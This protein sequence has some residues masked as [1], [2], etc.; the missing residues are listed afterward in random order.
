M[1]P[2]GPGGIAWSLAL[3]ALAVA[4]ALVGDVVRSLTARWVP[5]FGDREPIERGILDL[6]LGGA[7][8]Y[9]LAA[10]PLG[11]FVPVLPAIVL[12]AGAIAFVL[13][14]VRGP[15]SASAGLRALLRPLGTWPYLAALSAALVLFGTEVALAAPVA[16]GNTFDSSLYTTYTALLFLHGTIPVSFAPLAAQGVA[17]PQGATVWF[18][19]A[20]S[21]FALPP[22]R[23]SLLVT[24]LF[25]ALSVPAAFLLGRR[26]LGSDRAGVAVALT[27]ALL[28]S[29]NRLL[30]AGSNDFALA[31]PLVL[32]LLARAPD[33]IQPGAIPWG[34]ALGV[35]ALAGYA[36]A[37]NPVGSQW[38]FLTLPVAAV[39]VR[40]MFGG[41]VRRWWSRWFV[42]LGA[43]VPF[44]LPSL[45]VLVAGRQSPGLVPG[46]A[47]LPTGTVTGLG[48]GPL[49]GSMDPFLF[50]PGDFAFSPFPVLRAELA[51]LL[52]VGALGL[53][54]ATT[55]WGRT[56]LR[57][58]LFGRLTLAGTVVAVGLMVLETFAHPGTPVLEDLPF[59]T[60]VGELS[61]LLFSLYTFVAAY[62]L[63]F[64]FDRGR[65]APRSGPSEDRPASAADAGR[66]RRAS[67][68]A[69]VLGA[70]L[71]AFIALALLVP[72]V[73]T[74]ATSVPAYTETLY[75]DFSNVT[76]ADFA[77]LDWCGSN[78]PAGS[79]VL[80]APGSA[81]E[82]VPGYAPRLVLFYPMMANYAAAN[83]SY[84][85]A[86]RELTHG[87][88]DAAGQAAL[89]N[90]AIG[91][92]L[93]TQNNSV[94][95]PPFSPSPL[96]GDPAGFVVAFHQ[97][98][99]YA[100]RVAATASAPG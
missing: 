37:L 8:L 59:V 55:A 43:A 69:P 91:W 79:R 21:L 39:L 82:F 65:V 17:Y 27:V 93:V 99:A 6:Y 66:R 41:S 44:V 90:L 33:W 88:L 26:W 25:L 34:N 64:L 35:G 89:A 49:I 62:P 97:G 81:A 57:A 95:F 83:A 54:G 46:S 53:I 94:L 75:T 24:P 51:I 84:A 60:S 22:A 42:A 32:V 72:G 67:R 14:R 45:G 48:L 20:Q 29:W 11:V 92:I 71:A 18:A 40:P 73:V 52:A 100:F 86:V 78:L 12:G 47:A 56:D 5:F 61:I 70:P 98:D 36:A 2:P 50:G 13:L 4:F 87:L 23:A 96:L 58:D 3:L 30:V 80:V 68:S 74:T 76:A 15:R 77:L 31:F 28:G 38:W 63:A 9:A 16:T 1:D 85:L 7:V 10:L 19:A